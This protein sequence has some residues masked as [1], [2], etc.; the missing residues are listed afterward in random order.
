MNAYQ[1]DEY[2]VYCAN[3]IEEAIALY[4]ANTGEQPE[5]CPVQL[6]DA[7]LDVQYPKFDENERVIPGVFTS[8]RKELAEQ[9]EP[10][11]LCVSEW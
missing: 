3:S 11:F 4:L 8:I 2:T 5:E 1:M 7:A 9:K 6:G 10:G